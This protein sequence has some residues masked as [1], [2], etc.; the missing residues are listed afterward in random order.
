MQGRVTGFHGLFQVLTDF[1]RRL[2]QLRTVLFRGFL[3]FAE[4][5]LY[6]GGLAEPLCFPLL[7]AA[8]IQSIIQSLQ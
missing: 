5:L 3:H 4:D 7:Q 1:V 8:F 6:D 2:P